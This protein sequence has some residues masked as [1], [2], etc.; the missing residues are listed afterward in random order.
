M[1]PTD[2]GGRNADVAIATPTDDGRFMMELQ[3][4]GATSTSAND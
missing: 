2:L 4:L 3:L 1:P